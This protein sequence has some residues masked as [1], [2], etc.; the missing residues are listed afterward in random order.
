MTETSH[1]SALEA[2]LKQQAEQ[3]AQMHERVTR[4]AFATV[5]DSLKSFADHEA[6]ITERHMARAL[7]RAWAR[8]VAVGLLISLGIFAG[9]WGLTRYLAVRVQTLIETQDVVMATIEREQARRPELLDQTWGVWLHEAE[10]GERYVV[11]PPG[12]LFDSIAWPDRVQGQP[13]VLLSRE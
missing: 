13:A 7:F 8:P 6:R 1:V 12:T 2:R 5:F 10:D 9:S 3:D 11:L 4:S